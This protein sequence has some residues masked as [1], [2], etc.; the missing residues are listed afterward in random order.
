MHDPVATPAGH[1]FE[2]A[3]LEDWMDAQQT[4]PLTGA[5]LHADQVTE[6]TEL[7]SYIQGYQMQ[8]LSACS[9]APEAFDEAAPPDAGTVAGGCESKHGLSEAGGAGEERPARRKGKIRIQSRSVVD[10]PDEMRC[11]IDGKVMV[12]PVRC[13]GRVGRRRPREDHIVS[14]G[15]AQAI[16][17]HA[18]A[19]QAQLW[20]RTVVRGLWPGHGGHVHRSSAQSGPD[21]DRCSRTVLSTCRTTFPEAQ[22]LSP[23]P[24]SAVA[25]A[26][27]KRPSILVM[28][29][30]IRPLK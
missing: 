5:P 19:G 15:G 24:L 22:T 14:G 26:D 29:V 25:P 28:V 23:A 16:A 12:N 27:G 9:I 2:R 21:Q 3:A 20:P 4:E 8:M 18:G 10:C 6:A 11:A 7:Q 13:Q 17:E 30:V 1:V